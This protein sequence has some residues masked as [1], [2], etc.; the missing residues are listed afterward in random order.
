MIRLYVLNGWW[1]TVNQIS[2]DG[3]GHKG[4]IVAKN[5]GQTLEG[6]VLAAVQSAVNKGLLGWH[7]S[8]CRVRHH[9]AYYS[10]DR[11]KDIIFDVSI[12]L[13]LPSSSKPSIIWIWEC[14]DYSSPVPVDDLEEFHAKLEQIG[15][16]N[17][18]GTVVT[19]RGFQK[20]A[21]KYAVSKGIGLARLLPPHQI[22]WVIHYHAEQTAEE[23][24]AE[25]VE[26]LIDPHFESF[27]REAYGF[28]TG[29]VPAAKAS[30]EDFVAM[31]IAEW[32]MN[33]GYLPD[34]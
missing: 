31:Q 21:I 6:E 9:A 29:P 2:R 3:C 16:A 20:S 8:A 5:T 22:Q 12:E 25:V 17:T 23:L 11:E 24:A 33:Q 19:R 26:A 7:A 27:S 34:T 30:L 32:G 1:I 15:S 18:K 28:T 13:M 4:G 10:R 14:K